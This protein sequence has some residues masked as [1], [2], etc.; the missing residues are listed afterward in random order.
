LQS[1]DEAKTSFVHRRKATTVKREKGGIAGNKNSI[2]KFTSV[3]AE[4]SNTDAEYELLVESLVIYEPEEVSYLDESTSQPDHQKDERISPRNIEDDEMIITNAV[5]VDDSD[6]RDSE[7]IFGDFVADQLR[8]LTEESSEN[9][10]YKIM[11][12]ILEA[13]SLDRPLQFKTTK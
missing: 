7:Q 1:I 13:L 5:T 12:V 11:H 6:P 3:K 8:Q 2:N 4:K 9:A 10:K